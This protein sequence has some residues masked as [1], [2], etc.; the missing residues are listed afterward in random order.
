[1]MP[2]NVR[3]YYDE[4]CDAVVVVTTTTTYTLLHCGYLN[5]LAGA[6]PILAPADLPKFS[7]ASPSLVKSRVHALDRA[8][9]ETWTLTKVHS[10]TR[11]TAYVSLSATPRAHGSK[12]ADH[13]YKL[14]KFSYP[15]SKTLPS[16]IYIRVESIGEN[17]HNSQ[18]RFS[19]KSWAHTCFQST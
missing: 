7:A 15:S 11:V 5:N 9:P 2:L 16:I 19:M 17:I 12:G 6:P 14:V 1:M 4:M 8:H 18:P 13:R 10:S 3:W